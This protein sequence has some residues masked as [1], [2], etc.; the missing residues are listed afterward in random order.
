[1]DEVEI[2]VDFDKLKTENSVWV[3][4]KEGQTFEYQGGFKDINYELGE[5]YLEATVFLRKVKVDKTLNPTDKNPEVL[6]LLEDSGLNI[7]EDDELVESDNESGY[8]SFLK[9]SAYE[10]QNIILKE[11]LI[12]KLFGPLETEIERIYTALRENEDEINQ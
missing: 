9:T 1:M 3:K 6:W 7:I 11:K 2:D 12:E 10:E 8:K 5:D 4:D